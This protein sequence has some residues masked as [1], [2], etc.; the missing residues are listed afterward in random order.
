MDKGNDQEKEIPETQVRKSNT[1]ENFNGRT[2]AGEG[3][4]N[5]SRVYQK[6]PEV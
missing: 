2:K 3:G 6:N 5:N 4:C 1:Y